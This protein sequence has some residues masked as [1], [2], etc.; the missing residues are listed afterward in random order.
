MLREWNGSGL[1]GV[2]W[3]RMWTSGGLFVNMVRNFGIHKTRGTSLLPLGAMTFDEGLL[4]GATS[5][6][7]FSVH[8]LSLGSSLRHTNHCHWH[9]RPNPLT[10][11]Y[12]TFWHSINSSFHWQSSLFNLLKI[13]PA[14]SSWVTEAELSSRCFYATNVTSHQVRLPC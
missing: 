10:V 2:R 12:E 3:L 1:T 9:S 5:L 14:D 7:H 8:S 4:H 6:L 13:L 11:N